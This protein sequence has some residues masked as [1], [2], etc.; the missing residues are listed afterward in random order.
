MVGSRSNKLLDAVTS[1]GPSDIVYLQRARDETG[2]FHVD[3]SGSS[4]NVNVKIQGRPDST[5]GWFTIT[6]FVE[7]DLEST[8]NGGPAAAVVVLYPQMRV[9]LTLLGGTTPVCS[10]WLIE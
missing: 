7:G 4:L 2:I 9:N 8:T 6:N 3:F 1:T 10:A 5:A